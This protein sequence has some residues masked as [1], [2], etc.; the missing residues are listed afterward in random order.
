MK[1]KKLGCCIMALSDDGKTYTVNRGDNL[2]K[3]A[4][5]LGYENNQDF[6][7]LNADQ[8]PSL[9]TNPNQIGIGW[10]FK[11][12]PDGEP[13]IQVEPRTS[14]TVERGDNLYDIATENETDVKTLVNLNQD[15]YRS[16]RTDPGTIQPG[17][18]LDIPLPPAAKQEAVAEAEPETVVEETPEVVE[19]A[20]EVAETPETQPE[21][22]PEP[23]PA[24]VEI[25]DI[26][27]TIHDA[28]AGF[29]SPSLNETFNLN[30]VIP[31]APQPVSQI[32]QPSPL[33]LGN[34]EVAAAEPYTVKRGDNLFDI[35]EA[36]GTDVATLVKLNQ[37]TYRTLSTNPGAIN[38]GWK[39]NVTTP[40]NALALSSPQPPQVNQ[41]STSNAF[42]APGSGDEYLARLTANAWKAV[43][44]GVVE[45][46][47][48]ATVPGKT[49]VIIDLGHGAADDEGAVSRH[50]G[51][52]EVD[53]VDP[54]G[55]ELADQLKERGFDVVFTRGPGELIP[56]Y[57][58]HN[59]RRGP[60]RLSSRAARA[61]FASQA[62]EQGGYENSILLSLHADS[63]RTGTARGIF[64]HAASNPN[65]NGRVDFGR[66]AI[67]PLSVAL[68]KELADEADGPSGVRTADVTI[69]SRFDRDKPT[70]G[71]HAATLLE[72]GYLSN[73]RDA[74]NLQDMAN[75]PTN[76]VEKIVSGILN[77]Y[78]TQ[79]D[80][81]PNLVIAELTQ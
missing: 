25:S 67:N 76:V 32:A 78:N 55:A 77:F 23:E 61:E 42:N 75:D 17:W 69:I 40:E 80:Q 19:A 66:R 29:Q 58:G 24:P 7:D 18:V 8:Y 70:T 65:G 59:E 3:I 50:N 21:V 13:G 27:P 4:R 60:L 37:D 64:A 68:S 43:D 79:S 26:P 12:T 10:E 5:S 15:A 31:S 81:S 35:A 22:V 16:L 63:E 62:I 71:F 38:I 14:Y 72:L 33:T 30:A 49:L 48:V 2:T 11:T 6:I 39:L 44:T 28:P 9:L 36:H 34:A 1:R 57:T 51:L 45:S 54:V 47:N 46:Q 74:Q 41:S 52:N 20:P 73:R 56:N 53:I